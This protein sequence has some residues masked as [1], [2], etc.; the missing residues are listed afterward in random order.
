M[1]VLTA[2]PRVYKNLHFKN[3]LGACKFDCIRDCMLVFPQESV[4]L[5][6]V[7]SYTQGFQQSR[8]HQLGTYLDILRRELC[9]VLI[10]IALG[11][12]L[13]FMYN[14]LCYSSGRLLN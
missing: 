5:K 3:L 10:I 9:S 6:N 1:N 11:L 4:L 2:T 7:G 13:N 8:D 14:I 12:R